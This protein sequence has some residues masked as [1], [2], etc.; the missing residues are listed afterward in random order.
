M[1]ALFLVFWGLRGCY[2]CCAEQTWCKNSLL[3]YRAILC[4][5]V[6]Q[7]S[8]HIS[9]TYHT[10]AACTSLETHAP[11]APNF[12]PQDELVD[13]GYW[14]VKKCHLVRWSP[15]GDLFAAVSTQPVVLKFMAVLVWICGTCAACTLVAWLVLGM[16]GGLGCSGS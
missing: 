6:M 3:L 13:G 16:A 4:C 9:N 11:S 2:R 15:G 8:C 1:L 14:P 7:R 5:A 12:H 10:T